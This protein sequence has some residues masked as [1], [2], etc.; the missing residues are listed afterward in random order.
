M[1]LPMRVEDWLARWCEPKPPEPAGLPPGKPSSFWKILSWLCNPF[2]VMAI[3]LAIIFVTGAKDPRLPPKAGIPNDSRFSLVVPD[4]ANLQGP[5]I[6]LSADKLGEFRAVHP[7]APLA[8]PANTSGVIRS[9]NQYVAYSARADGGGTVIQVA[10]HPDHPDD[11]RLLHMYTRRSLYRVDANGIHAIAQKQDIPLPHWTPIVFI[12]FLLW[13]LPAWWLVRALAVRRLRNGPPF[14]A[15]WM[16]VWGG[17]MRYASAPA[18]WAPVAE[19]LRQTGAQT[20]IPTGIEKRLARL[21]GGAGIAIRFK[22]TNEFIAFIDAGRSQWGPV[23]LC[24]VAPATLIVAMDNWISASIDPFLSLFHPGT[25]A[26]LCA[27][28]AGAI[29]TGWRMM[30]RPD[31]AMD[32]NH[33]ASVLRDELEK[34]ECKRLPVDCWDDLKLRN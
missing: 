18:S 19:A 13:I 2:L 11:S 3:W 17:F 16:I 22:P 12:S 28:G 34:Q 7:G 25:F 9:G 27:V 8:I 30:N 1:R 14:D 10:T 21:C 20:R 29:I 6:R 32:A 33:L 23:L 5:P 15:R 4:P 24:L 26:V 31:L